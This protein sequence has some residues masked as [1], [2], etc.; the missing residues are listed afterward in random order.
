MSLKDLVRKSEFFFIRGKK[1]RIASSYDHDMAE[2]SPDRLKRLREEVLAAAAES[3]GMKAAGATSV[4]AYAYQEHQARKAEERERKGVE[5]E[6]KKAEEERMRTEKEMRR[7][8]EAES[9]MADQQRTREERAEKNLKKAAGI[10]ESESSYESS[11]RG[12]DN[13][14][15]LLL[16]LIFSIFYF[17]TTYQ[18]GINNAY[19]NFL[20]MLAS[21]FI[22]WLYGVFRFSNGHISG[23]RAVP[24]SIIIVG[25]APVFL[26]WFNKLITWY[27]SNFPDPLLGTPSSRL[28][29]NVVIVNL[30]IFP[31]V[32]VV[33][34]FSM[35]F[36]K[37]SPK[38]RTAGS[39]VTALFI[40]FFFAGLSQVPVFAEVGKEIT[41]QIALSVEDLPYGPE[42]AAAYASQA[43]L[44]TKDFTINAV[45]YFTSGKFE[46]DISEGYKG[47]VNYAVPGYN[48]AEQEE[49][50]KVGIWLEDVQTGTGYYQFDEPRSSVDVGVRFGVRS[51]NPINVKLSCNSKKKGENEAT[52]QTIR[53]KDFYENLY[54]DGKDVTCKS[55]LEP[56]IHEVE[57]KATA[58]DLITSVYLPVNF[59][60]KAQMDAWL[61]EEAKE[62]EF[63]K[64]FLLRKFPEKQIHS[65]YTPGPVKASLYVSDFKVVD[66]EEGTQIELVPVV[67]KALLEPGKIKKLKAMK[68]QVIP[69]L[70]PTDCADYEVAGN[71]LSLKTF[72]YEVDFSKQS[73]A[74]LP[75][76]I[77]EVENPDEI[78]EAGPANVVTHT[79]T[80]QILYDYE[81]SK[82][83]IVRNGK[84]VPKSPK[85]TSGFIKGASCPAV[86]KLPGEAKNPD[87][88]RGEGTLERVEQYNYLIDKYADKYNI[89]RPLVKAVVAWESAGRKDAESSVGARGL[90]QIMPETGTSACASTI[91]TSDDLLDPEKNIE[92]GT[93]YLRAQLNRFQED[94]QLALAAYNAGPGAVEQYNGIPPY[95]ETQ[96]YVSG[97]IGFAKYYSEFAVEVSA[98]VT[99]FDWP[100][101]GP[102]KPRRADITYGSGGNAYYGT[103]DFPIQGGKLTTYA[104]HDGCDVHGPRGA[105]VRSIATGTIGYAECSVCRN[106]R[107]VSGVHSR[108]WDCEGVTSGQGDCAVGLIPDANPDD[109]ISYLHLDSYNT[110][111]K[112]GSKIAKGHVIG[113]NGVANNDPH[114]H[115]QFR[116][117]TRTYYACLLLKEYL[118]YG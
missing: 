49:G 68:I 50:P 36:D 83:F 28:M 106:G 37:L 2:R 55:Q 80:A 41:S 57:I 10:L 22:A 84:E 95:Q 111:L 15:Y 75:S 16:T 23:N 117:D 85:S 26:A 107:P 86:D 88:V 114:V 67:G 1:A 18:F 71:E 35:D 73:V 89:C 61:K 77:F 5:E 105:K 72:S 104:G 78:L 42:I 6:I 102:E 91:K 13:K 48:Q 39:V 52:A 44:L 94:I 53:G 51:H 27:Y 7:R 93:R 103:A 40:L 96:D 90:M 3:V 109:F 63:K 64:A 8:A 76:C 11:Y 25:F 38:F 9:S 19:T 62:G 87:K 81:V 113:T 82:K 56:G 100:K 60:S 79:F 47:L 58:T 4:A 98:K 46:K 69:G 31:W 59:V 34:Y 20:F 108:A 30:L 118:K 45:K 110:E 32:P 115:V 112:P 33:T 12:P 74:R 101:T 65:T 92:C 54:N 24:I 14:S 99:K 43:L 97:V 21:L 17:I 66:I 70:K 29:L 116:Q